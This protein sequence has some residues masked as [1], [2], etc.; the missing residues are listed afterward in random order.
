LIVNK[1]PVSFYDAIASAR[2][3]RKRVGSDVKELNQLI[4]EYKQAVDKIEKISC[5][6]SEAK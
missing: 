4:K 3:H 2:T 1:Q 6:N 5:V